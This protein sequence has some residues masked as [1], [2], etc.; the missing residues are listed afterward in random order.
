MDKSLLL[1]I[2]KA[3]LKSKDAFIDRTFTFNRFYMALVLILI[4]SGTICLIQ[5]DA[6][7]AA[8]IAVVGMAIS[9]LWWLNQ[10]AYNVQIKV[11]YVHVLEKLEEELPFAPLK[12]EYAQLKEATNLKKSFIFPDTLKFFSIAMFFVFV[13]MFLNAFI[14]LLLN[15][16]PATN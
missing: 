10:D 11:K 5:A 14:P 6:L 1:E 9:I 15:V 4:V 7:I 3:H 13:I 12:T 16:L 8:P 2:Y